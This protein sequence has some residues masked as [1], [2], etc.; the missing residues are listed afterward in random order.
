MLLV[1]GDKSSVRQG[2]RRVAIPAALSVGR[3]SLEMQDGIYQRCGRPMDAGDFGVGL[4]PD[5][6]KEVETA[7]LALGAGSMSGRQSRGFVEEEQLG[8]ATGRQD[9]AMSVLEGQ[10][11]DDP[12]LTPKWALDPAATV[13]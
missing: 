11:T 7:S 3:C 1:V 9:G 8:V 13:M 5:F 6:P 4:G 10:K 2:V 12:S